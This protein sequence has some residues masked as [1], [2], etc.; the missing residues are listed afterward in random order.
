MVL[1]S[2]SERVYTE[3]TSAFIHPLPP[4][5]VYLLGYTPTSGARSAPPHEIN[6]LHILI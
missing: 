2:D 3:V 6:A 5:S 4:L 1:C